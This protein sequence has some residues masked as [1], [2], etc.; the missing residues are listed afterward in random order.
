MQSCP[1]NLG[2]GYCLTGV[3]WWWRVVWGD[4]AAHMF[5]NA[6]NLSLQQKEANNLNNIISVHGMLLTINVVSD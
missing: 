1:S 5:E 4:D 3:V 6:D 2:D